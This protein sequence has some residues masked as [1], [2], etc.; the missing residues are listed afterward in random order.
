MLTPFHMIETVIVPARAQ[1]SDIPLYVQGKYSL[2]LGKTMNIMV[3]IRL[4]GIIYE[5]ECKN[6]SY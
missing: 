3:V 6:Y 4:T 5:M 1:T 2:M